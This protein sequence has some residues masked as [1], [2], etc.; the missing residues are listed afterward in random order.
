MKHLHQKKKKSMEQKYNNCKESSETVCQP[1]IT[2]SSEIMKLKYANIYCDMQFGVFSLVCR[3]VA[4]LPAV[5]RPKQMV[6]LTKSGQPGSKEK[7]R[8][9]T[10]HPQHLTSFYRTQIS[11][12]FPPPDKQVLNIWTL[13]NT[14]LNQS[15]RL[16]MRCVPTPKNVLFCFVF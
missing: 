5:S 4:F 16:E 7:A 11:Y 3:L 1:S 10:P 12:Q 14:C 15:K 2:K 13:K 6:K 8:V 9:P